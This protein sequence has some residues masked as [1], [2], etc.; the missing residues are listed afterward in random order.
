M[1]LGWSFL[2]HHLLFPCLV[3]LFSGLLKAGL[4]NPSAR[5]FPT[6]IHPVPP[7]CSQAKRQSAHCLL[8]VY[9]FS[10]ITECQRFVRYHLLTSRKE[11]KPATDVGKMNSLIQFTAVPFSYQHWKRDFP[12]FS[13]WS[14]RGQWVPPCISCFPFLSGCPFLLRIACFTYN[15]WIFFS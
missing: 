3:L 5:I 10:I 6:P 9:Y 8:S 7:R 1:K 13:I 4:P 14:I 15:Y 11:R 2:H 12:V